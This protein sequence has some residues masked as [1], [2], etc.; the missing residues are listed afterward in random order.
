MRDEDRWRA[1]EDANTLK[2]AELVKQDSKRNKNA[3]TIVNSEIKA[4]SSIVAKAPK[5]TI[6]K[7]TNRKTKK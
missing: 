1:E 6:R 3:Q 2:R 4:L 7:S 5:K